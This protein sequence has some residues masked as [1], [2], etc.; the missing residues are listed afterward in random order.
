MS[1]QAKVTRKTEISMSLREVFERVAANH[2]ITVRRTYSNGGV[3]Y[4]YEMTGP[5]ELVRRL[6]HKYSYGE[7]RDDFAK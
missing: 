6:G 4:G 5:E 2:G 3:T 7:W 1:K